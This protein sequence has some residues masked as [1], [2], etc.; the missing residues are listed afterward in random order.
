M[1]NYSRSSGADFVNEQKSSLARPTTR[2]LLTVITAA[3]LAVDAYVH[4]KLAPPLD[5]I[6]GTSSPQ[7]SQGELFRIEAV[8]ALVAMVL[9][10]TTRRRIS[11]AVAFLV[12]VGGLGAVL[13]YAYVNVGE[14][15]PLPNMYD[16]TWYSEKIIS[17]SAQVVAAL[18]AL[19]LFLR[20]RP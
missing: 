14:I 8:M 6:V 2:L 19:W 10:V 12:A 15:G 3:G 13:L 7:I 1:A 4:W 11:A 5:A 16:P 20:P 17:A 9:V 18:A